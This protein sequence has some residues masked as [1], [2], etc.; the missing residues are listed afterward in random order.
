MPSSGEINFPRDMIP[1]AFLPDSRPRESE[2]L[3]Q[4]TKA[5]NLG[6]LQPS[7]NV[8]HHEGFIYHTRK[9]PRGSTALPHAHRLPESSRSGR[10]MA[11]FSKEAVS[12]RAKMRRNS[13]APREHLVLP[14][15]PCEG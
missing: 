6:R 2:P 9:P 7:T 12:F 14:T 10:L 13:L 3:P 4:N 8:S 11:L 5:D 1:F 15:D